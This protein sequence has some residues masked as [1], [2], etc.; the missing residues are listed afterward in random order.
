MLMFHEPFLALVFLNK[1]DLLREK[2]R[3]GVR[4]RDHVTS[5]GERTNDVQ[6]VTKCEFDEL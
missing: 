1:C 3:R 5:F 2:L 4:V 6:T